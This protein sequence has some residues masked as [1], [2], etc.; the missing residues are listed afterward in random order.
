MGSSPNHHVPDSHIQGLKSV[1]FFM[2]RAWAVRAL[3]ACPVS[4]CPP[5]GSSTDWNSCGLSHQAAVVGGQGNRW[6]LCHPK[7]MQAG[8]G[9]PGPESS[10]GPVADPS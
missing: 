9:L 6:V 2:T 3:P 4:A 10:L 1:G 8:P 7:R 5:G